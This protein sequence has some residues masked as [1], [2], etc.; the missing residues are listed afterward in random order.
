MA[1]LNEYH[2]VKTSRALYTRR[3][4]DE[5]IVV[6]RSY[7]RTRSSTT[8]GLCV[9]CDKADML[10]SVK[11][12]VCGGVRTVTRLNFIHRAHHT[13]VISPHPETH[14]IHHSAGVAHAILLA[15]LLIG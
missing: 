5:E 2:R 13:R 1:E 12:T 4:Y 15:G 8:V 3:M 10:I 6:F 7:A 11:S 9:V 14:D